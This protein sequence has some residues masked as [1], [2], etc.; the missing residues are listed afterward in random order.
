MKLGNFNEDQRAT[1]GALLYEA[2]LQEREA[3]AK[4]ADAFAEVSA[5][6][7]GGIADTAAVCGER[8]AEAIR[9][10]NNPTS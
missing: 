9:A 6:M 5:R 4:I 10:Q 3:C 1:I 8:I 7:N 2:T